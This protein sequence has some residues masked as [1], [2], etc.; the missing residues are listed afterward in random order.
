MDKGYEI[1]RKA[2]D[3]DLLDLISRD[4]ETVALQCKSENV[5]KTKNG[6][7]KQIQN[8]QNFRVFSEVAKHIKK[9]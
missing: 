8:C 2:F 5:F 3:K 7:V 9:L 4:F 1:L 6:D